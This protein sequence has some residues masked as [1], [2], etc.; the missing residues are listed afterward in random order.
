VPANKKARTMKIY[1]KIVALDKVKEG[2]KF[3][4]L[5]GKKHNHSLIEYI[6][7]AVNPRTS[8]RPM[9]GYTDVVRMFKKA[10]INY[11]HLDN[12]LYQKSLRV[13]QLGDPAQSAQAGDNSFVCAGAKWIKFRFK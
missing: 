7:D 13:L 12:K 9:S 3:V 8:A 2:E 1:K 5:D 11:K 10:N 4:I 6:A